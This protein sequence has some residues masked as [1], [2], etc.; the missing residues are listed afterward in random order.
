MDP[1]IKDGLEAL[2]AVTFGQL[3]GGA[4]GGDLAVAAGFDKLAEETTKQTLGEGITGSSGMLLDQEVAEK[5][6]EQARGKE[7]RCS[8]FSRAVR[9][10]NACDADARRVPSCCR[11]RT[12]S[13][14]WLVHIAYVPL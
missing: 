1:K 3:T 11:G 10:K 7:S 4:V 2:A 5:M 12:D 14:S 13:L 6:E 8:F 9:L